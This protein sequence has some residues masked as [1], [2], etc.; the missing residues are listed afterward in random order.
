M[1]AKRVVLTQKGLEELK[2]KLEF[3]ETERR[4]EVIE[5]IKVARSY[6]DLSENS[7]YDEA[8]N[9]Q[10]KV[11]AEIADLT[12]MLQNAEIIDES[13]LDSDT[14]SLGSVVRVEIVTARGS[15]EKEYQIL[16]SNES[17]P[18]A[19]K[20]SEDSPVGKALLGCKLGDEVEVTT[21]AGVSTYRILEISR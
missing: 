2:K 12:V 15:K 7:E 13:K 19:G 6:G 14:V 1:A 17:D 3:L 4:N 11:E 9:E 5:K 18:R 8:K 16:G 20:I 10:A 21:P